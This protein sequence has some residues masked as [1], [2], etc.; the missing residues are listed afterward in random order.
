MNHDKATFQ[1]WCH[2]ASDRKLIQANISRWETFLA[3]S[4]PDVQPSEEPAQPHDLKTRTNSPSSTSSVFWLTVL[5]GSLAD[6]LATEGQSFGIK[7]ALLVDEFHPGGDS[8]LN[9]E[10]PM[11]QALVKTSRLRA[12]FRPKTSES[13]PNQPAWKELASQWVEAHPWSVIGA[14]LGAAGVLG[15]SLGLRT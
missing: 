15:Y 2:D 14:V 1:K 11:Q 7:T 5:R 4:F 10:E 13:D 6:P 3:Q 12:I 8:M 9:N